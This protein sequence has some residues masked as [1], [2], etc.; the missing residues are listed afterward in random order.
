[1][2]KV[3]DKNT[4]TTSTKSS[5]CF[6]VNFEH[7]SYLFLVFLFLTLNKYMLVGITEMKILKKTPKLLTTFSR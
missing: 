6:F 2:F 3:N 7:I 5:W 4:K 1:M